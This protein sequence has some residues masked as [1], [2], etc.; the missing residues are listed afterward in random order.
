MGQWLVYG[1]IALFLSTV[2]ALILW[3]LMSVFFLLKKNIILPLWLVGGLIGILTL[4]IQT[5]VTTVCSFCHSGYGAIS[6]IPLMYFP[7]GF[8]SECFP[9]SEIWK[10][11]S[12]FVQKG[13]L[14]YFLFSALIYFAIGA[15]AG[16]LFNLCKR[17]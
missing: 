8:L 16:I 10:M 2:G 9:F 11:A 5:M 13:V 3:K 12:P 15:A 4:L 6:C 14:Q 1:W 7:V 17:K